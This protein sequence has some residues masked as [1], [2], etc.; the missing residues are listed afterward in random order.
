MLFLLHE[1]HEK[2]PFE[3]GY[4]VTKPHFIINTR[5]TLRAHLEN[6]ENQAF[7]WMRRQGKLGSVLLHLEVNI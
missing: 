1:L 2:C 3:S 5:V 4:V 6:L 7:S